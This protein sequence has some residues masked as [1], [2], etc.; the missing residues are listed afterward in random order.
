MDLVYKFTV[1]ST[2]LLF[3]MSHFPVSKSN[4]SAKHLAVYLSEH[5]HFL[6]ENTCRFIKPGINDT[7]LVESKDKQF[8]FRVYS[9]NWR[10]ATEIQQELQ[11]LDLLK[12]RGI[13]V[14]YPVL[15]NS[16]QYIQALNAPEGMRYGV[17]F[18]YAKGKKR[19]KSS[20][21]LHA[22]I[23]AAM[24]SIHKISQSRALDRPTYNESTLLIESFKQIQDFLSKDAPEFKWLKDTHVF[25]LKEFSNFDVRQLRQ[26]IVHLDIWF[27]NINVTDQDEI[28][29]F[30][31]DF[32]GN[33]WL[34]LDLAYYWLALH[35][36][37]PDQSTR[38]VKWNSFIKGYQSVEKITS[39]ELRILPVLGLA[40]Y[41]FYF[42]NM[43]KRFENW[44]NFF[45][46]EVYI[47]QYVKVSIQG[48]FEAQGFEVGS[49]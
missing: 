27:D 11:F 28:T 23:G 49:K 31:F 36:V 47:E 7:Y 37:E 25:L 33:G 41:Y 2:V 40:L 46:N 44:S 21:A 43:C 19:M 42:G 35:T 29:F 5:Y 39:E 13:A 45:L 24:A 6:S 8:V 15:D 3:S 38:L 14:S 10:S 20:A 30:D 32:C 18:S 22:K 1:T 4:L 16:N 34:C 9:Y 12:S 17:L 26:G 48:Y